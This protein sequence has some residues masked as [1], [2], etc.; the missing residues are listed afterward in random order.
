MSHFYGVVQGQRGDATRCGSKGSGL[1]AVAA[2]WAGAIKVSLHVDDQGRDC[3]QVRQ[4][5]WQN[6]AGINEIIAE[7]VLGQPVKE[8]A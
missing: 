3:F 5:Q 1:R 7:G 4:V 8:V 6:G 2:S